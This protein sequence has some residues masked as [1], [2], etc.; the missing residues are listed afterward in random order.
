M[1][2]ECHPGS[3]LSLSINTFVKYRNI[4][5]LQ[6][7]ID[8]QHHQ[9]YRWHSITLSDVVCHFPSLKSC[10]WILASVYISVYLQCANHTS[11]MQ[12]P[13]LLS[14]SLSRSL[15]LLLYLAVSLSILPTSRGK[16]FW[17]DSIWNPVLHIS[18]AQPV[19]IPCTLL[20]LERC[21]I[22]IAR[23]CLWLHWAVCIYTH[24]TV[25]ASI[26]S[27]N[28]FVWIS[29]YNLKIQHDI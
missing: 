26:L 19:F 23:V 6:G 5:F 25:C 14:L 21:F 18:R 22:D 4:F 1:V 8:T 12:F 3:I 20:L 2:T 27:L 7:S 13:L 11:T 15:C 16:G 24:N 10:R 9:I 29:L 17:R 28:P